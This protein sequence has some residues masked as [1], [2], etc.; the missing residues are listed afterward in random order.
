MICT[1]RMCVYNNQIY[2]L[3]VHILHE[4]R[5]ITSGHKAGLDYNVEYLKFDSQLQIKKRS[6]QQKKKKK[7]ITAGK[8]FVK[9][10]SK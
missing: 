6:S 4:N 8:S 7:L 2:V 3:D 10:H 9:Q 5:L 1:A